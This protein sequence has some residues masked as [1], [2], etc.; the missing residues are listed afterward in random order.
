MSRFIELHKNDREEVPIYINVNWI[1]SIED[2]GR[3][4][5]TLIKFGVRNDNGGTQCVIVSESYSTVK[6]KIEC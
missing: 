2:Y 4:G 5:G 6:C 3:Q 1:M